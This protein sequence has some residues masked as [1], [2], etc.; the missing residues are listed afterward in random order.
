MITSGYYQPYP[1]AAAPASYVYPTTAAPMYG[2]PV[3]PPMMFGGAPPA[4]YVG[5][6]VY[7]NLPQSVNQNM[8]QQPHSNSFGVYGGGMTSAGPMYNGAGGQQSAQQLQ[9]V[10]E[11]LAS[12][13]IQ[14]VQQPPH[15]QVTPVGNTLAT[16]LWQ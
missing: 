2:N 5:G 16:N 12:L 7:P 11:Q 8:I 10:R 3:A 13:Q 15:A 6:V 1:T 4:P 14:R 9:Q